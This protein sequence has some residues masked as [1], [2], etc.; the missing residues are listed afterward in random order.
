MTDTASLSFIGVFVAGLLSFFSPCILPLLPVYLARFAGSPDT[1]DTG[2]NK[3][4]QPRILLQTIVF[5]IGLGTTFVLMG[6]G[7]GALGTLVDA[8]LFAIVG[9]FVILLLGLHQAGI[10]RI[11]MLDREARMDAGE[12]TGLFGSWLLGFTF[13][14]GWTPCVGP[15]LASVLV[16]SAQGGTALFGAALM[17]AFTLGLAVPFLLLAVFTG[18]LV[19]L[20][21]KMNRFMPKIRL[22]GGLVI[23]AVGIWMI[24][25]NLIPLTQTPANPESAQ[26]DR[27]GTAEKDFTL[28]DVEGNTV[29]LS[30]FNGKKVYMKFWGTWC[31]ACMQGMDEFVAYADAQ[32]A[33][34]DVEVITIVLPGMNGE[35]KANEFTEWYR[36]QGY[37]FRVLFDERGTVANQYQVRGFP[38]NVFVDPNGVI[39]F[40]M[41]GGIDN[42]TIG[43][44]WDQIDEIL[45]EQ[46][47]LDKSEI[48]TPD[49]AAVPDTPAGTPDNVRAYQL[50]QGST[51]QNRYPANPN[52]LLDFQVAD[53]KDIWLAGGCFWGVEAYM[54]RV[55]GV[56]DAVSGY[57]NGTL[58]NPAYEQ[59]IT[60]KTGHA[61]T[62]HVR[63]DPRRVELETIL[64]H[65]FG[66]IDPTSVNRQGNDRGT[67]YRTG[68]YYQDPTDLPVIEQVLARVQNGLS[69]PVATEVEPLTAFWPAEAYHQDY[70]ETNP[71]GYCHVDFAP[72][73]DLNGRI[74]P[75]RYAV[76]DEA[77]LRETLT[78]EQYAVTRQNGTERAFSNE[79]WDNHEPGLY[80]DIVTGEPLFSS[81]DK[82]DSGCGWPSFTRPLAVELIRELPDNTLGMQRIEVRSRVGDSHLGHV[83]DDGPKEAGGLR[84][85]IN[86]AALRFIP[87]TEM[88]A[89]GYGDL[90]GAVL[91]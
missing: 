10:I 40:S 19:V 49:E 35:M 20:F 50:L 58:D 43:S 30:D 39:A 26:A 32:Q 5:V 13:S 24:A 34:G 66:I 7:A 12:K 79:Y 16:L 69:K 87:L 55:Y 78:S 68:I 47:S 8:R 51:H 77:T 61:E 4:F 65:Y 36:S 64:N 11:S 27:K 84:Y 70:L 33:S 62:V 82:Y 31:S 71:D 42:A 90:L 76:P 53:L 81:R 73:T 15:I 85:C 44:I 56:A 91:T 63:Y 45:A 52:V 9:G 67:Q 17:G 38:T 41:A 21:R 25:S 23:V 59:I 74:D 14:F 89:A 22:V 80:V 1:R 54:A 46:A 2:G 75:A 57:A 29:T 28:R 83:F 60:G 72:L 3:G 48:P 86:S 88:E 37:T 6:F 18:S